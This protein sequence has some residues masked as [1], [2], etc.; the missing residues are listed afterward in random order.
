MKKNLPVTGVEVKLKPDTLIV[1]RTDLKGRIE[2][3]NRDFLEIS[4]FEESEL[5]GKAHNIVRH[6]DMP[7]AAFADLWRTLQAGRPWVGLVKN[8]CKNGDHYWVQANVT[9]LRKGDAVTGYLSVRRRADPAR[10]AEA[11]AV[12]ARIHAGTA[13][14]IRVA[15]GAV[16]SSSFFARTARRIAD[17]PIAARSLAIAVPP[18]VLA[19]VF[20]LASLGAFG[21]IAPATL[22]PLGIALLVFLGIQAVFGTWLL[23]ALT[24]PLERIVQAFRRISEGDFSGTF[25]VGRNDEI[26]RA[27]QNLAAMQTRTG[28]E[29][30]E[31]KRVSDENLAIRTALDHATASVVLVDD[32]GV[33]SYA[34]DAAKALLA[35]L[36]PRIRVR[37]PAFDPAR[38]VGMRFD[39]LAIEGIDARALATA[40]G[41]RSIRTT[42]GDHPVAIV[43]SPVADPSGRRLG[44]VVEWHDRAMEVL[45]ESDVHAV[46]EAASRGEF[47][48]RVAADRMEGTLRDLGLGINQLLDVVTRGL[49]DLQVLLQ[50]IAAG[51]LRARMSDDYTG[52]FGELRDAANGTAT[53]LAAV[54]GRI[55]SAAESIRTA[56]GEIADGNQDLST[57]TE[58]QASNL[59]ETASAMDELTSTVKQ[60]ADNAR[61]ANQLAAGA[62]TVAKEGG[63][64]MQSVVQRMGAIAQASSRIA[65]IVTIIDGI[66]FQ[67]NILALNASVEAARAGEQGK[68]FAVV[69][70]EVRHLAQRSASAAKEIAKLI[71]ESVAEIEAG[72]G[73]V[74]RAGTTM[75]EI[76]A[77]VERVTL[78]IGEIAAA[79]E[80]QSAG[81]TEVG[82]AVGQMDEMTQQNAALVEEAAAAAQSL[83]DQAQALTEAVGVFRIDARPARAASQP[84]RRAA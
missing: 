24:R 15:Q 23:A 27:F 79:S 1:S 28:F 67:T 19:F 18:A 62:S 34:N 74:D 40:P 35:R 66:A 29:I 55:Q 21:E 33:V 4:G 60:N 50:A 75:G 83:R 37:A 22:R 49:G 43:P 73:L 8:R 57:R 65:D 61:Q 11:E 69:A 25:G 6:P 20:A 41:G 36:A 2:Y 68:G 64:A 51:D 72:S 76:V 48:Q 39:G 26:G 12:Y 52:V 54:V 81:I 44:T 38:L 5:I 82:R 9:P 77:A 47:G 80:Q 59:A 78:I 46:L 70:S 16:V 17:L 13:R 56:S 53:Q 71:G 45:L 42:L 10:I 32:E 31:T 3:V 63:E 14:G 58:S 84:V 7:E 30:A